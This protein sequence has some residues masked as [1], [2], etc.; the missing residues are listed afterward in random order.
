M[1]QTTGKTLEE[2]LAIINNR[3]RTSTYEED[4]IESLEDLMSLSTQ[5]PVSVGAVSLSTVFHSIP[6]TA[7]ADVQ[8]RIIRA[9]TACEMRSEFIEMLLSD[10]KNVEILLHL[11]PAQAHQLCGILQSETLFSTLARHADCIA[12]LLGLCSSGH[13][14]FI[15]DFLRHN[16]SLAS[17]LVYNGILEAILEQLNTGVP[18]ARTREHFR[19]L[20][21]YIIQANTLAQDYFIENSLYRHLFLR[22]QANLDFRCDVLAAVLQV[23]NTRMHQYQSMFCTP[24]MLHRAVSNKKYQFLTKL[25]YFNK[26]VTVLL[27]EKYINQDVLIEDAGQMDDAFG[28]LKACL[29][30]L[31]TGSVTT[32]SYRV[33]LLFQLRGVEVDLSA[34][35]YEDLERGNITEDLLAYTIFTQGSIERM[36][37]YFIRVSLDERPKNLLLFLYILHGVPT[38]LNNLALISRLCAL[39]HSLAQ[40]DLVAEEYT[41]QLIG[42]LNKLIDEKRSEAAPVEVELVVTEDREGSEQE[43]KKD[44]APPSPLDTLSSIGQI[45][46]SSFERLGSAFGFLKRG[47]KGPDEKYDL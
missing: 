30:Y 31:E 22:R 35:L 45:T 26:T 34:R 47:G 44:T 9:V 5:H 29:N 32:N 27:L 15:P 3:V 11:N 46:K 10:E 37:D 18:S 6:E 2:K 12:F 1:G 41:E 16:Q 24:R 21:V 14:E 4:R 19:R 28:L 36:L 38:N 8:L 40:R 39:R 23:D 7:A 43:A 17:N 42:S 33:S 25:A 20:I 13:P